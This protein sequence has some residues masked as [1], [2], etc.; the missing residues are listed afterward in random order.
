MFYIIR[1][2]SMFTSSTSHIRSQTSAWLRKEAVYPLLT[3]LLTN[4]FTKT[5]QM[6]QVEYTQ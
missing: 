6:F 3:S 1:Y 4:Y 5:N 2:H